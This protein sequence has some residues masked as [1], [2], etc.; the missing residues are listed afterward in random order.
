MFAKIYHGRDTAMP[1][2]KIKDAGSHHLAVSSCDFDKS[3]KF[4][5]EG[6]GFTPK[7]R[8]GEGNGR[9]AL[10]DIGDGSHF[11]IFANGKPGEPVNEKLVHFAFKTSDPDGAYKNALAAGAVS[12]MEPKD[13]AIPSEP[14]MPVRIAFVKGPDGELLEFFKVMD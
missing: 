6:L 5:T 9:A 7:A 14:P 2:Q 12:H 11:E 4:Y 13:V 1:N 3:V 10:L 8:W